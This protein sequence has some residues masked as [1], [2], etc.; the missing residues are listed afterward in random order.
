MTSVNLMKPSQTLKLVA[1][2][3]ALLLLG[4]GIGAVATRPSLPPT[5]TA[6][7]APVPAQ[8]VSV[9]VPASAAEG[10]VQIQRQSYRLVP[11]E[12]HSA[13]PAQVTT[14]QVPPVRRNRNAQTR[15]VQVAS[16]RVYYNYDQASPGRRRD[17]WWQ[18]NRRDV[19]TIAA[20]TGLGAGVGALAGG[21]KG[22]G[23]G[24]LAGGGGTALYTYGLRPR[25]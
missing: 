18:R 4:G 7:V 3:V 23:V 16:Q 17:S 14:T 9:A 1:G 10:T 20:G 19:L 11:V 2:G 8:P 12:D 13:S 25:N 22:A 6:R 15:Q 24:A 21:K 5:P